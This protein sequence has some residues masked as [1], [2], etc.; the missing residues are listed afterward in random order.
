MSAAAPW[1]KGAIVYEI[2]VRSFFDSNGDGHGDLQGVTAKL[3]YIQSLGADAIWLSPI[4]PSPN[5]DWGYD[6]SDYGTVHPD[7]GTAGDLEGLIAGAH[8]RG[9]K[10]LLDGVLSHTSDQHAWFRESLSSRDNPNANWYVWADP[11]P[12]G[13]PPN[14]WLSAF[15]GPAWSYHPARRQYY[16]HKFLRQQPKL[17]WRNRNARSAALD[18]L[19]FWLK[20][21]I[22]GFRLDVAN[23]YLHDVSLQ[24]NPAVP[25]DARNNWHWSHAPHLQKHI[26]DSNLPEN[27]S[28]LDDI[29]RV[30][31]QY[32]D[33]F[34]FGEFYEDAE[35][36]GGYLAPDKGLH[37]SYDFG[38]LDL[39]GLTAEAMQDYCQR[40]DAYRNYWPSIAFSNHDVVR[41]VTRLGAEHDGREFGEV[42][43]ALLLTLKGTILL[44]QGEELGLP[45]AEVS[46]EAV[47]DPLGQLYY[48]YSK[49][50]DGS[51]T[52][53]PWDGEKP[54]NG[55]STAKP[56]LPVSPA[57]APL[58]IAAQEVPSSTLQLF[59]GLS[60]LRKASPAIRLG[61]VH[62]RHAKG[63]LAYE[64]RYDTESTLCVFNLTSGAH[65]FAHPGLTRARVILS[66]RAQAD[67][68][69]L[70]FAPF[71]FWIGKL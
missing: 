8:G 35:I 32:Q 42:A 52:P 22:D 31:E 19:R 41:T 59:R 50:R 44:Y 17:N 25:M 68:G 69:S 21:G 16:F 51:R 13:T 58:A 56:W 61:E 2:Y 40:L 1:W 70:S 10:V 36:S 27:W 49:G 63:I 71:G 43:L 39:H 15:G 38:L 9:I 37:S 5:C 66:S 54:E 12:D 33:R 34:V 29:R 7:F 26:H 57:Q 62:F 45:Q 11:K 55:F 28:A 14:N 47:R 53:M 20:H 18:V 23:S 64:R 24:D 6:V 30:V 48:P 67:G 60:A 4:H 3:D 46:A 65:T